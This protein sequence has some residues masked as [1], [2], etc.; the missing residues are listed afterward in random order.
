MAQIK[1]TCDKNEERAIGIHSVRVHD[2]CGKR[3]EVQRLHNDFLRATSLKCEFY[4]CLVQSLFG[5]EAITA[6]GVEIGINVWQAGRTAFC[7]SR[8]CFSEALCVFTAP[9]SLATR[10]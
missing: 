2:I 1:A 8:T 9:I 6:C 7:E 5:W 10:K 4:H 3:T